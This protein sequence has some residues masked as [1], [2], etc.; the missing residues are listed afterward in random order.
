MKLP[1]VDGVG[2]GAN[3]MERGTGCFPANHGKD[4]VGEFQ[5]SFFVRCCRSVIRRDSGSR[6][7]T[8]GSIKHSIKHLEPPRDSAVRRAGRVRLHR[9]GDAAL[10]CLGR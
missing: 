6:W 10:A 7:F 1:A 2:I 3:E 9:A 4:L 5:R 8:A